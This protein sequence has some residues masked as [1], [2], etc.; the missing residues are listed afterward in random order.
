MIGLTP[1]GRR[2]IDFLRSILV[3]CVQPNSVDDRSM[4][5]A[6]WHPETPT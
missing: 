4:P 3:I 6:S 1:S 5:G 2:Y